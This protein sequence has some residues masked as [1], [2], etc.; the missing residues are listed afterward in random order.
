MGEQRSA[1]ELN[2]FPNSRG[3][4]DSDRRTR[5]ELNS[6]VNSNR[7][8]NGSPLPRNGRL[9]IGELDVSSIAGSPLPR[10]G[11][12]SIGELAVSSIAECT[13][14]SPKG[15][16]STGESK[17]TGEQ[18]KLQLRELNLSDLATGEHRVN[19]TVANYLSEGENN[20]QRTNSDSF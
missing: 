11:R 4:G 5:C 12:T 10:N 1:A 19:S 6:Q 17:R 7:F 2:L 20:D 9:S 14:P 18:R 15:Q 13:Q 3:M 8:P 16:H